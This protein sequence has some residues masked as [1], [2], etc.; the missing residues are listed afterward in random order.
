M[1]ASDLRAR[2]GALVDPVQ[3]HVQRQAEVA[4][5][6]VGVGALLP[7]EDPSGEGA[8]LGEGARLAVEVSDGHVVILGPGE[9]QEVLICPSFTKTCQ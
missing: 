2:G 8:H 3:H 9:E 4:A 7:G 5:L 1:S 6:A